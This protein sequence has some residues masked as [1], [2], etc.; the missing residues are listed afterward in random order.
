MFVPL[1]ARTPSKQ[2]VSQARAHQTWDRNDLVFR[3]RRLSILTDE[4]QVLKRPFFFPSS[5]SFLA[6]S[7]CDMAKRPDLSS[8]GRG[9]VGVVDYK[10]T[11][12][13]YLLAERHL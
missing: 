5:R 11:P 2:V 4:E 3:T 9:M 12:N 7:I 13:R 8:G 10:E 1:S 6:H